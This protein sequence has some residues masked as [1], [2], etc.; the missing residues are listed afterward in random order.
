MSLP[1]IK[2]YIRSGLY[3]EARKLIEKESDVNA[4]MNNYEENDDDDNLPLLVMIS[5][6][7]DEENALG[8]SRLLIE[9]GY[10]IELSDPNGLCALNYAIALKRKQLLNLLLN[11]FHFELD[12]YRDNYKNTF[13]HY[14]YANSNSN[15]IQQ[16][17][18]IY[19]KYYKFNDE[20]LKKLVNCDGLSVQDLHDYNEYVSKRKF[21]RKLRPHSVNNLSVLNN[22]YKLPNCFRLN[23]NPIIIC[24]YINQVFN[25]NSTIKNDLVYVLNNTHFLGNIYT[26]TK[27]KLSKS[28]KASIDFK[29]NILYQIKSLNKPSQHKISSRFQEEKIK[30][31][32][33]LH[34]R[35]SMNS[36]ISNP[37]PSASNNEK[38]VKYAWSLDDEDYQY[39]KFE[40]ALVRSTPLN[41]RT[42]INQLF[43]DYSTIN[44]PSYRASSAMII[45]K[46]DKENKEN[47]LNLENL[48]SDGTKNSEALSTSPNSTTAVLINPQTAN[49]KSNVLLSSNRAVNS[50]SPTND[51]KLKSPHQQLAKVDNYLVPG[52]LLQN[53]SKR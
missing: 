13:F 34:L 39:F 10:H 11:S 29:L 27:Q 16:F 31:D 35:K 25:T 22:E 3:N 23:S 14:V 47:V 17:T 53:K 8:L 37:E 51:R 6:I 32:K 38:Y 2:W 12:S 7:K 44:S 28:N 41:W 46:L 30:N 45:A 49:T 42:E 36:T 52:S 21:L 18:D 50:V 1:N 20:L 43:G 5:L 40:N 26:M 4:L 48:N 33:I 15:I 19:S 9:K 24:N